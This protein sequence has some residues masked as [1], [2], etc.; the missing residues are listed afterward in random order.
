MYQAYRAWR[1]QKRAAGF[2][3]SVID[4]VAIILCVIGTCLLWPHLYTMS[5]FFPFVLFHFFLF[6]NVF[7]I[8]RPPEL[9]WAA[10]FI[11]NV[12][13]V[14][15]MKHKM[16][17]YVFWAQLPVT[18]AVL[19]YGVMQ[20]DYHGVGYLLVPWGRRPIVSDE[21]EPGDDRNTVT[22]RDN[23]VG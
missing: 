9:I 20:K 12:I 3:F 21:Q 18:L 16:F 13:S 2:R 23:P 19:I 14:L 22:D 15:G 7:R 1:A 6:C 17:P 5:L 10:I 8:S 11:F 4:A